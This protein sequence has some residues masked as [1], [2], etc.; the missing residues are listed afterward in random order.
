[1]S[2]LFPPAPPQDAPKS[3]RETLAQDTYWKTTDEWVRIADMTPAAR[4]HAAR[5]MLA[6]AER[7]EGIVEWEEMRL[8]G[9]APDDVYASFEYAWDRRSAD[10]QRWLR[11]T[12]LYR[13]LTAGPKFDGA[14]DDDH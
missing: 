1:M 11:D 10:P 9:D 14:V 4:T 6:K 5:L 8:L 2:S 13:A 12:A 3:W 7:I